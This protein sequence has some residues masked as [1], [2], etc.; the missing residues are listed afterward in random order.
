MLQVYI[1]TYILEKKEIKHKTILAWN[2]VDST[3]VSPA[4]HKYKLAKILSPEIP[5]SFSSDMDYTTAFPDACSTK[6]LKIRF[7]MNISKKR[8]YK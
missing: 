3:V 2:F 8:C 1:G 5:Q 7:H 4:S 6:V